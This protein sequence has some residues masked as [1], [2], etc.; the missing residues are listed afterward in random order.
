MRDKGA[1]HLTVAYQET[2]VESPISAKIQ[3][4]YSRASGMVRDLQATLEN[5][6]PVGGEMRLTIQIQYHVILPRD[7]SSY[8]FDAR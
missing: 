7:Q 4:T 5:A 8:F 3:I 1:D 2:G 6:P